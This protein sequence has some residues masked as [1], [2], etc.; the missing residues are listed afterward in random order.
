MKTEN[1]SNFKFEK[2]F[3]IN[4]PERTD[5]RDGLILA[6]AVSNIEVEFVD[7]VHGEKIPT[8]ALPP[9]FN[10][11]LNTGSLGAWRAHIN[12]IRRVVETGASTA[13]IIEDDVDW[14]IRLRDILDNFATA[15]RSL[16]N[17]STSEKVAFRDLPAVEIHGSPYGND[18][19]VLWL[20]HCGME[21]PH[22]GG[23]VIMEGDDT[24]P[25]VR[26]LKSFEVTA[27]SPL[28]PYPQHT[29]VFSKVGDA[30]CSLAYAV[31]QKGARAL[32]NDLG[33][34]RLVSPFDNALRNW[35]TGPQAERG[36][37]VCFGVLPQLFDHYRRYVQ[38]LTIGSS[39]VLSRDMT[40]KMVVN[41]MIL[42]YIISSG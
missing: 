2:I 14:D 16:N 37:H 39:I 12:A 21:L 20:G 38:N 7:G 40:L 8:K 6:T 41:Y 4:L 13:L 29:R 17:L 42:L 9:N 33:L 11:N 32:L 30:T 26:Y 18:W 36:A 5:H 31:S 19:D 1:W 34:N 23:L 24:V 25:E 10:E 28:K 35:C 3:A 22:S 15:S 27:P